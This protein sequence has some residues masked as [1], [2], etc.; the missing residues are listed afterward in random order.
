MKDKGQRAREEG[1]EDGKKN[2][3]AKDSNSGIEP[4]KGDTGTVDIQGT[5]DGRQGAEP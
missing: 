3:G 4:Q 5:E 1:T 2:T